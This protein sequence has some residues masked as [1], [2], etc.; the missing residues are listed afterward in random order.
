MRKAPSAPHQTIWVWPAHNARATPIKTID[1]GLSIESHVADCLPQASNHSGSGNRLNDSTHDK[2]R[3][4]CIHGLRE[5][6]ADTTH[7]DNQP[8]VGDANQEG[9]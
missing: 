9:N 7:A 8:H 5:R 1:V 3:E 2:G 4:S 6:H